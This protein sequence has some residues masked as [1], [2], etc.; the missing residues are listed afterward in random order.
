MNFLK[1]HLLGFIRS[2]RLLNFH[3]FIKPKI[4]FFVWVLGYA[5]WM[6]VF[7]PNVVYGYPICGGK[8][9]FENLK[10]FQMT[11][12]ASPQKLSQLVGTIK[13]TDI[14]VMFQKGCFGEKS[15]AEKT[16]GMIELC[17]AVN[18]E[19]ISVAN[20]SAEECANDSK[21]A[22][23]NC[24]FVGTRLQFYLFAFVGGLIG[25]GV[26]YF[27][28]NITFWV[29]RRRY[30][31]WLAQD[32]VIFSYTLWF[33]RRGGLPQNL[34]NVNAL[35]KPKNSQSGSAPVIW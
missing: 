35:Q 3:V 28:L 25:L 10:G 16:G 20:P 27:I 2:F 26:A 29:L 14:S 31:L 30:L 22:S 7:I 33:T 32:I 12:V 15:V 23:N 1:G 8:I 6:T 5:V 9:A 18:L 11:E 19:G 34:F 17:D 24:Y 21:T 13:A 4:S